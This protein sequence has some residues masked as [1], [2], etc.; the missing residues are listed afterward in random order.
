MFF[1]ILFV[2]MLLIITSSFTDFCRN[3]FIL[4]LN[5]FL[6]VIFYLIIKNDIEIDNLPNL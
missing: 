6:F 3:I 1:N 5:I 2:F 4:L